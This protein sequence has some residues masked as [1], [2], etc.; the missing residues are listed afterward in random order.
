VTRFRLIRNLAFALSTATAASALVAC[1]TEPQIIVKTDK[2]SVDVGK[3]TVTGSATIQVAPDCADLT[4][5]VT[6]NASKQGAAVDAARKHA[7]DL[8]AAIK[9]LGLEDGD[10]KLST[11]SIDPVY[12]WIGNRNVFKGYTAR[13]VLTATT[14]D[15]A[16]LGPMMEAGAD[17]G[18]TEISSSFRRSDLEALKKQV[19]EQALLAA[20]DKAKQTA[21][22][23]GISLGKVSGVNENS[24]SYMYTNQ[25]FPRA[26]AFD[27]TTEDNLA[28]VAAELQPLTMDIQVTYDLG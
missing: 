10:L 19:R 7:S 25:Y 16:Q 20:K 1:K 3:M 12:E 4:M 6:A 22:V 13:I 18:A 21:T 17:S 2:D 23:L 14:K 28:K 26:V 9:K 5:T 27:A 8:V 11:M 15:F 24:G